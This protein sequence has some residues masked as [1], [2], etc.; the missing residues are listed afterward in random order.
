MDLTHDGIEDIVSGSYPGELYLFAG[1]QDGKFAAGVKIQDKDGKDLNIGRAAALFV[2]DWDRDGD[3]D[4]I[5]GTIEGKVG[6]L[7]NEDALVFGAPAWLEA[8]GTLI[9]VSGGN[10]GPCVAD[11]DGDGRRDL[12]LGCGDGSVQFYRNT[13]AEGV[14][15]LAAAVELVGPSPQWRSRS[16]PAAPAES[17]PGRGTRAKVCVAD[18]N[19]DGRRDLLVG[20][21]RSA[22][23]PEPDLTEDL[24]AERDRLQAEQRELVAKYTAASR[25]ANEKLQAEHGHTLRDAPADRRA[26][27]ARAWRDMLR[28][29]P[30]Y[31]EYNQRSR[32]IREKLRPLVPART[33]HGHVW[34]FLRKSSRWL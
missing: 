18:W 29:D 16:G 32:E 10:A 19:G 9:R 27:L 12:I 25:R 31:Q 33:T 28:A 3:L 5:I 20:G 22:T 6:F 2:A 21:F 30:D 8:G 1:Q 4:L 14:P 7:A 15:V 11:W 26:E 17:G 23:G 13:A 34:V 24:R